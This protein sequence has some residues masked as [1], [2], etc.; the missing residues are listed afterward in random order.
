MFTPWHCGATL[1]S[2]PA[3][4]APPF[5]VLSRKVVLDWLAELLGLPESFRST[6]AAGAPAAGGGVIQGTA[7]EAVVVALLAARARALGRP[8]RSAADLPRLVA[9]TSDQA[10]PPLIWV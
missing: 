1:C 6:D 7:S 4:H 2:P 3:S 9:Y 5:P 10:R 8:E